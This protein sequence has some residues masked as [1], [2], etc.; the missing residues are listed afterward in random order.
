M[1][2]QK[3]EPVL[4]KLKNAEFHCFSGCFFNQESFF[5]SFSFI[6]PCL[7]SA[8][9]CNYKPMNKVK[10]YYNVFQ[11]Y[12]QHFALQRLTP[13]SLNTVCEKGNNVT[14]CVEVSVVL[15][16]DQKNSSCRESQSSFCQSS[17][18]FHVAFK[19]T[20]HFHVFK[21]FIIFSA[22]NWRS[23]YSV[24]EVCILQ[25]FL[26]SVLMFEPSMFFLL[27]LWWV[28]NPLIAEQLLTSPEKGFSFFFACYSYL[29]YDF[30]TG[31]HHS[32]SGAAVVNVRNVHF[33]L[34][35]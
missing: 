24:G 13:L 17:G 34:F 26:V 6:F 19:Q 9:Q 27:S 16:T 5:S 22:F 14:L 28:L 29:I 3:L 7:I 30:P 35:M 1:C 8:L 20:S 11:K 15:Q 21:L 2:G 4:V 31:P 12:E 10:L 25:S 18:I 32:S 33:C 23:D